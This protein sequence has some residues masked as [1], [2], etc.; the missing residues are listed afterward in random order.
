MRT[1]QLLTLAQW[2]SPAYPTGG[3]AWS[4]GLEA[5]IAEGVIGDAAGLEGWLADYLQAGPGWCDAVL[6]AAAWRADG[7]TLADIAGLA[8]ALC[9]SA[10]RRAETLEQGAAFAAVTRSAWALA[11]PDMAYPVAVGRA[12]ALAGL[13]LEP[14]ISVFL[15]AVLSNQVA[16][17]QRLMALGQTEAQTRLA[18]LGPV[19]ADVADR[20]APGDLDRLG[21]GAPMIDIAGMRQETLPVRVFRS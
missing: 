11:L 2:L 6:L 18:A 16:A 10:R 14:V 3:F 21:T 1:E 20:A 8:S 7:E 9:P 4:G 5:A 19:I 13:P 17:A 12:A 15:H